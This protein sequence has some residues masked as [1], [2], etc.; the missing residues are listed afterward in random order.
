MARKVLN[1]AHRGASAY[2][3]ENTLPAFEQALELGADMI[4]LDLHISKDRELVVIHDATL[5]RTTNGRGRVRE[6]DLFQLK[7]LDAGSWFSPFFSRTRIPTL[8]EVLELAKGKVQLDIEVKGWGIE[9]RGVNLIRDYSL[10][11]QVLMTSFDHK[12]L[13]R[14]KEIEPSIK[15]GALLARRPR[16]MADIAQRVKTDI[17]CIEH[18]IIREGD[19]EACHKKGISLYLWT[20][21]DPRRMEYLIDLGVDGII[22]DYPD[23]LRK[24]LQPSFLGL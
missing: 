22:T 13:L 4:E 12:A 2:T 10:L 11:D 16:D 23:V 7:A 5:E 3:P 24:I 14:I 9:E 21:N 20:V 17:L 19:I 6:K 15:T 18:S 1:I 8:K